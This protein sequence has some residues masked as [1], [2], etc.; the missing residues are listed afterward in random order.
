MGYLVLWGFFST[1]HWND[2]QSTLRNGTL[3]QLSSQVKILREKVQKLPLLDHERLTS[4]RE[5]RLAHVVLGA[6]ATGYIWQEGD[7]GVP[8]VLHLLT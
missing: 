1:N 8:K 3:L 7:Q 6:I 5:L 2:C 4:Y